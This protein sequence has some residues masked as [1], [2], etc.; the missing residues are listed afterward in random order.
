MLHPKKYQNTYAI[1]TQQYW[2]RFVLTIPL[3]HVLALKITQK[4][5]SH[6]TGEEFLE[7]NMKLKLIFQFDDFQEHII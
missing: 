6:F 2:S 5:I 1:V 3:V 4:E 7:W